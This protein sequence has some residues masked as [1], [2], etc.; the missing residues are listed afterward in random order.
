MPLFENRK[1]FIVKHG[2]D[3]FKA[4]PNFIWRTGKGENDI[5]HRFD[6]IQIGDRWIGFA[7][8]TSDRR[9]RSLSLV[10]GFYECTHAA[11]Y[12]DIPRAGQSC[13][14]GET[15]AWMI[16][17]QEF[18]AQPRKGIPVGVP[19]IADLLGRPIWNNQALVPIAADD[20][21]RIRDYTRSRQLDTAKIPLLGRE[22]ECEQELLAIVACGHKALGIAEIVRVR[23]AFPDLLVKI[24]GR[25]KEVHLELEIY[26]D[27]FFSHG[28]HEHV[29]NGRF[30]EDGRPVAV[31]CWIDNNKHVKDRV[32]NVYEL[33]SLIGNDETLARKPGVC[34]HAAL[35]RI[36]CD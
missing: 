5:P 1:H 6:Q 10:T 26:S 27:G 32:H 35:G 7:Y 14:D 11:E 36:L 22:P 31:L 24:A 9:E 15:K 8:T 28:H 23:K 25:S 16:E 21:E 4:L 18:G 2:L 30:K 13:S 17:G 19:P 3:S 33:Q 20:F 29:E 34:Y 12:L